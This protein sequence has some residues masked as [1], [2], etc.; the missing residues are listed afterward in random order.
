MLNTRLRIA[1]TWADTREEPSNFRFIGVSDVVVSVSV[2]Q[3]LATSVSRRH[4]HYL[5]FRLIVSSRKKLD[6]IDVL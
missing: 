6:K 2:A 3:Q 4:R 5:P 1:D